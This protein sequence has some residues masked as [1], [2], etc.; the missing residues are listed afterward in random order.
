MDHF[1]ALLPA[2]CAFYRERVDFLHSGCH[3]V[4]EASPPP[5][6]GLSCTLCT[7]WLI[8]SWCRGFSRV[9]DSESD[10]V[11]VALVVRNPFHQAGLLLPV[12][13]AEPV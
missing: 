7:G 1:R 9:L 4:F 10:A 6:V 2:I 3:S 5:A 13:I 12:A 11:F 8:A